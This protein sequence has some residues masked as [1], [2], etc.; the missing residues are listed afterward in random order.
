M[1]YNKLFKLLSKGYK[2][3]EIAEEMGYSR[4]WISLTVKKL[5]EMDNKEFEDFYL[6]TILEQP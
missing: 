3:K 1:D 5:R 4:T 6:Y 2:I